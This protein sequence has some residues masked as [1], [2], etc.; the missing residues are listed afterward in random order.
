MFSVE[1]AK[2]KILDGM[3]SVAEIEEVVTLYSYG[4]I[5]ASD[6]C[7]SIQVPPLDNSQMDGY[8]VR[9][10]DFTCENQVFR[11]SDRIQAGH[12]SGTLKA[13]TCAR[14]YTGAPI[15]KG[16]DAV[17]PQEEVEVLETGEVRFTKMPIQGNWIRKA[18]SDIQ[19][20]DVVA[21]KG[22]RITPAMMGVI[23]SIGVSSVLV[24]KP[25]RVALFFTGD[26]LSMPGEELVPGG[27][28]NSNRFVLRGLL[29]G[30]GC[31]V[32]DY[33]NIPDTLERTLEA[34]T[35]AS[36]NADL[37]LTSGGMSVGDADFI[38]TAVESLGKI[39]M[40]RVAVKPGKPVAKGMVKGV[41]FIGLPGNPVSGLVTFLLF[42][43]P[44]IL[45]LSGRTDFE[46]KSY[47]LPLAFDWEGGSRREFIRVKRN[48]KGELECFRSQNSA[49]LT[50]CLWAD[51]LADIPARASLRKGDSVTYVPFL[52]FCK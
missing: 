7:S 23:A 42:A 29:H 1:Q 4:R 14:I 44:L 22:T 46:V 51:G 34:F 38:K 16:A 25:I 32:V 27:I 10:E 8:A 6:I 12:M 3:A 50:S 9:C 31:D 26:E 11:V 36:R 35:K 40:W 2:S 28:Y 52:E 43:Q 33:G 47:Q 5:L 19:N 17:I 45:K 20:G 13:G 18:G 41:P 21:H 49:V 48:E 39:D 37:I 30:I 15:P 24:Y